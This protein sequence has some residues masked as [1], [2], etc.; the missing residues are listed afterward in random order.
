MTD[1]KL[2]MKK[3]PLKSYWSKSEPVKS[4]PGQKVTFQKVTRNKFFPFGDFFKWKY[5]MIVS[6]R[7]NKDTGQESSSFIR[8]VIPKK[9]TKEHFLSSNNW[10]GLN[11]SSL[12]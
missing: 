10:L 7:M 6:L 11:V 2:L 9:N 5:I 12:I 1:Q 3:W 8:P 4:Y